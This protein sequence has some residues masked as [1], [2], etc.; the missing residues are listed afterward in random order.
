MPV[1][2]SSSGR[3]PARK[4]GPRPARASLR[5]ALAEVFRRAILDAAAKVFRS[6]GFADAKMA[7]IARRAGVA[8]GTLYN[9]FDSKES[10]FRALLEQ[11]ADEFWTGLQTTAAET[12]DPRERLLRV[13]EA[14]FE[15]LEAHSPMCMVFE[16]LGSNN[17]QT[18]RRVCGP[19]ADRLRARYLQLY[20]S[21]LADSVRAGLVRKELPLADITLAFCGS[22]YG[23]LRGWQASR[24]RRL[25]DRAAFLV[26]LF[27]KGAGTRT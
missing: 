27:L 20:Q 15:H 9:Y 5:G 11:S 21:I 25:R 26:D 17:V 1:N 3:T 14:T 8:A 12:V 6:E 10:I 23:F 2:T 24:K 19:A 7:T 4:A 22:V 18:V 13:T 16:Q